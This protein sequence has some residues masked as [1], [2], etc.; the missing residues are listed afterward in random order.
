MTTAAELNKPNGPVAAA[1]LAGG[2][3]SAV[4]GLVTFSVELSEGVKNAMSWYKPVGPLSGKST[5]G[6]LA[7]VISWLVLNYLWQGKETNFTRVATIAIVLVVIGLILTFPPF[8]H[9]F[10]SE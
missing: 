1:L 8:W 9:L 10:V 3:G 5:L 7:F 4:L 6:I 2:I